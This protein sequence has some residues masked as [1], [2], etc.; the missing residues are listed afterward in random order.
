MWRTTLIAV[1][2]ALAV[3]CGDN[4]AAP[5]DAPDDD[6]ASPGIDAGIDAAPSTLSACLDRPTDLTRP[7]TGKLPCELIPPDLVIQP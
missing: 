4:L 7:P 2:A 1:L 3:G 5:I 6:D